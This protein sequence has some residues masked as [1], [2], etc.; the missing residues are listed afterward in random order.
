M[1]PYAIHT[2]YIIHTTSHTYHTAVVQ[3]L[4]SNTYQPYPTRTTHPHAP[5]YTCTYTYTYTYTCTYTSTSTS[6]CTYTYSSTRTYR[7]QPTPYSTSTYTYSST[8]TYRRQ[9]TPYIPPNQHAH[10][11]PTLV[12]RRVLPLA[13]PQETQGASSRPPGTATRNTR[14][15]FKKKKPRAWHQLGH[16]KARVFHFL[17]HHLKRPAPLG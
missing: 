15:V 5:T 17:P 16:S 3:R 10:N 13:Q 12:T 8:R 1:R 11:H 7:R 14:R 9:P 2:T 6:T 4:Y